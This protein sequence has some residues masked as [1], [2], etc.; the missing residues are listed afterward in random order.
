M[1][2]SAD[3]EIHLTGGGR[4][5]VTRRGRVIYREGGPWS[6]TVVSLLRH[7]EASGFTEAPSVVGTGFDE[8]GRETLSFIEGE[9]VH[10]APWKDEAFPQ[11]GMMLR[12]LH[13][14]AASFKF[15]DNSIWRNWFG[16]ELGDGPFVIGHCDTG[17]WNIVCRSGLPVA[18]ID[19]EV[20]GP[21][22]VDIELAQACWLNAQLYDDDIAERVGLGSASTRAHQVRMLLDGYGLSRKQRGG[23]VDK[24]VMF[25]V[26]DAAEQAKEAVVTPETTEAR[27]LWA[28]TWRTRSASWMLRHRRVLEAALA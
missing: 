7:L 4:T 6:P 13:D 16:R 28:I 21:V 12:R 25:A 11:L 27:P 15:P 22:R 18:L 19:W 26:H 3:E 24:L 2:S 14:A 10:P 20:A 1:T 9:L 17:P 8:R 23:F 5:T